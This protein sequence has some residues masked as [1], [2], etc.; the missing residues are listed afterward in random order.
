MTGRASLLLRV[1][2]HACLRWIPPR[3]EVLVRPS[4]TGSIVQCLDNHEAKPAPR[5]RR[6]GQVE[7]R[8]T[9]DPD[10]HAAYEA[11]RIDGFTQ[12]NRERT[13]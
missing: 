1:H 7:Y 6:R 3:T 9:V 2:C 11:G 5:Q 13:E 8:D 10:L 12:A 4:L